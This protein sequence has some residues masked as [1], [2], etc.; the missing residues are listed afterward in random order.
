V[1]TSAESGMVSMDKSLAMMV[2]QGLVSP[3]DALG[4]VKDQDFFRS[5]MAR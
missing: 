4:Y 1:H 3:E 5:I 2:N